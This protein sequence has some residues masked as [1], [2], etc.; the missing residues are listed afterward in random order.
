MGIKH[1][2]LQLSDNYS[3][4][5]QLEEKTPILQINSNTYL[6]INHKFNIFYI[7]S[8]SIRLSFYKR[9][10]QFCQ[11][12]QTINNDKL[13]QF[14]H[15]LGFLAS[16]RAK[17]SIKVSFQGLSQRLFMFFI[18]FYLEMLVTFICACIFLIFLNSN[19]VALLIFIHSVI[20][21][22][23]M[24]DTSLS[25]WTRQV[26]YEGYSMLRYEN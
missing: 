18:D 7:A 19:Y 9:A 1:V 21:F 17:K 16:L 10:Q 8:T 11:L 20:L 14:I 13:L 12:V 15:Y 23:P 6:E 2:I 4:L 24:H 25:L 22:T 5:Y 26:S 3:Y